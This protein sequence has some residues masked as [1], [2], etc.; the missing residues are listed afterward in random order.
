VTGL[1]SRRRV[2]GRCAPQT[3]P[4]PPR[5]RTSCL[6]KLRGRLGGWGRGEPEGHGPADCDGRG[7]AGRSRRGSSWEGVGRLCAWWSGRRWWLLR[8]AHVPRGR[9]LS[10]VGFHC[11]ARPLTP[12]DGSP[13]NRR[14]TATPAWG[15]ART[16]RPDCVRDAWPRR[17]CF[18]GTPLRPPYAALS[19]P[20]VL[21]RG[22]RRRR[23]RRSCRVSRAW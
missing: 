14:S 3:H 15:L 11:I 21:W 10:A 5:P 9:Q 8:S 16:F 4:P 13:R 18:A 6:R 20:L 12:L 23:S 19:D 22:A 7:P 1:R 2:W 17:P